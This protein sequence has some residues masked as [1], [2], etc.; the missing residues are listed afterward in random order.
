M[1][2]SRQI[3]IEVWS[4]V[5]VQVILNTGFSESQHPLCQRLLP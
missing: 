1:S 2:F 3:I 5:S 4:H